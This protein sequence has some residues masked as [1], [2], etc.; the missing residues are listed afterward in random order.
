M[1]YKLRAVHL[2]V[3]ILSTVSLEGPLARRLL[4]YLPFLLMVIQN[5]RDAVLAASNHGECNSPQ[6]EDTSIHLSHA[7]SRRCARFRLLSGLQPPVPAAIF[8]ICVASLPPFAASGVR[9]LNCIL[10]RGGGWS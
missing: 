9:G 1:H 10:L 3:C 5:K 8:L 2:T 7:L 6:A 4:Q